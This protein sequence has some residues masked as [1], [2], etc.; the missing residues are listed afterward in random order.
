MFIYRGYRYFTQ[1]TLSN[2]KR[3]RLHWVETPE[4][5]VIRFYWYSQTYLPGKRDISLWIDL[6]LPKVP[7]VIDSNG[8]THEDYFS[9]DSLNNLLKD[10]FKHWLNTQEQVLLTEL[11][12]DMEDFVY[13]EI[14][15][16]PQSVSF[17]CDTTHFR[18]S[19]KECPSL[20]KKYL[21]YKFKIIYRLEKSCS[22]KQLL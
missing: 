16:R 18:F 4:S 13:I 14:P 11:P 9:T 21:H 22:I 7:K 5:Q 1:D 2:G 15:E 10:K 3:S 17:I 19:K 20:F 12:L 6:G 8:L